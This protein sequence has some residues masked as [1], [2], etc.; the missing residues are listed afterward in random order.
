MAGKK[1][2][3]KTSQPQ[4]AVGRRVGGKLQF[5][6][7]NRNQLAKILGDQ[8]FIPKYMYK[9]TG[10]PTIGAKEF[11]LFQTDVGKDDLRYLYEREG[12]A[13]NAVDIPANDAF[14]KWFKVQA[15]EGEKENTKLEDTI[16]EFNQKLNVKGC[17]LDAYRY[18]RLYGVG[19]VFLG[20]ADQTGDLASEPKGVREIEYLVPISAE[21]IKEINFEKDPSSKRYGEIS[22]YEVNV[23]LPSGTR[24]K[25]VHP[26]RVIHVMERTLKRNPWGISLLL[27]AYDLFTILKNTDWSAGEAYY[28]SSSPLFILSY[29]SKRKPSDAELDAA[30]SDLTDI[31]VRS[32]YI[33][34]SDWEFATVQGSGRLPDPGMFW[35]PVVERIAGAMKVPKQIL[36]GTSA[37]ALASGE[38]N[39]AQYYK[40]I[41]S[42]QSDFITPRLMQFYSRLQEWRILPEGDFDLIWNPLWEMDEKEKA[43]IWKLKADTARTLI[44]E[45][46]KPQLAT[47]E[48]I[49]KQILGL[50]PEMGKGVD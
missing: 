28:Q 24:A 18:C 9:K 4:L 29:P 47:I 50:E 39:L 49:R 31:S 22:S 25:T 15:Y 6:P 37:G 27:P 35:N 34:P 45:E 5:T 36:L 10:Y 11:K 40:D 33:K 8:G 2:S 48:E 23:A 43:E 16:W 14:S 42:T 3:R 30:E 13:A 26:Q 1:S 19:L 21:E 7:M 46:G 17:F 12:L 20:L 41:A 44:G 38:V 32:R